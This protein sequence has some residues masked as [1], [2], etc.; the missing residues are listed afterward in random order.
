MGDLLIGELEVD[1]TRSPFQL[2]RP[3]RHP[4][5]VELERGSSDVDLELPYQEIAHFAYPT[6]FARG[7][8]GSH[9]NTYHG[10]HIVRLRQLAAISGLRELD[11][12]AD[13]WLRYTKRWSRHPDYADGV[14]WT[15]EGTLLW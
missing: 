2:D 13:R 10:T 3:E 6:N 9:V 14:C 8:P 11:E 5:S 7:G 12:W 4:R 15:P 1:V